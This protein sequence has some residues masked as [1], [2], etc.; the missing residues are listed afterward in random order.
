MVR[1]WLAYAGVTLLANEVLA[2]AGEEHGG[3]V[4]PF[5]GD[6]GN[7][8]WT[9]II[10]VLVLIVLGKF[11]WGPIL[12]ALQKREEFIHDSLSQAKKD[13]EEAETRL[14]EYVEK[15][16]HAKAEA[17]ALV[18]E[19][20]RDAEVVKKRIEDDAKSEADKMVARAKREISIATESA[21]KDIYSTGAK[22]AT[23]AASKIISKELNSSEHESL[24]AESIRELESLNNN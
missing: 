5:A 19:G 17:S 15:I 16:Q 14:K 11:A 24:I 22:L 23:S 1:A 20:R 18:D 10:F 8:I 9:V 13:R 6:V 3:S 21:I 7:A 2:A 12:S 4:N